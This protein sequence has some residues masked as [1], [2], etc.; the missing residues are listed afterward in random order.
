M[1]KGAMQRSE[2]PALQGVSTADPQLI[3]SLSNE[4]GERE[5]ASSL[6]R[7]GLS[8]GYSAAMRTYN[9]GAEAQCKGKEASDALSS[10]SKKNRDVS[11]AVACLAAVA[12]VCGSSALME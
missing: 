2:T 7:V 10:P 9:Y 12:C 8:D 6:I 3:N 5:S 11:A 1:T 4:H